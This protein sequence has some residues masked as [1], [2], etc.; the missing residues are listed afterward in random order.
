MGQVPDFHQ[1]NIHVTASLLKD[2]LRSIP[3][4]LLLSGNYRLWADVANMSPPPNS[5]PKSS[6]SSENEKQICCCIKTAFS[7]AE[8]YWLC[9][10]QHTW[11]C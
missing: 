7:A 10:P 8:N 9:C 5:S 2:Y 6:P 1:F 3:G 11:F 4:Q